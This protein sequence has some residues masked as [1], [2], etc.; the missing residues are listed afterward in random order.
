M[1]KGYFIVLEGLDGSGKTTVAQAIVNMLKD[2]DIDSIYTYEPYESIFTEILK[3]AGESMGAII[4][5]LLMAA[6]RYHHI[7]EVI[8]PKLK[9]GKVVVSDRYYY[10]S[11]AYQGAR[12]ADIAWI[13]AVNKFALNPDVAIYLDIDPGKGLARKVNTATRVKYLQKDL[14]TLK[15][16]RSIYLDLVRNGELLM[17]DATKP[18]DE[19]IRECASIICSKIGLLCQKS[20]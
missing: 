17:V 7:N 1:S 10:S 11:I 5:T 13:R 2:K 19:V 20:P 8:E 15:K 12:G 14:N 16:V 4:E 6:D 18:L 9:E 3:K